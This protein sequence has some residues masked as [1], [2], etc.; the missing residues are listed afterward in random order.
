MKQNQQQSGATLVVSLIMLV[1]LTLL[2]VTAIR[3]SNTNLR[4]AGN[5][6][7]TTE[8]DSAGLQEIEQVISTDFTKITADQTT[9][10]SIGPASYSVTVPKPACDNTVPIYSNDPS[11]NPTDAN[12]Q[13]C[14]GDSDNDIVLDAN[15]KP[16]PKATKCN[17]Q[18][19]EVQANVTD[20]SSGVTVSHYQGIGK[21]TYLPTEC[22]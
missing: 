6:Q 21:R 19:W 2:V 12:D 4:I 10:I 8:A 14:F 18:Q 17:L 20:T 22:P 16:I 13:L 9:T 15:G 3:S 5:M 11:L 1:V 7:I